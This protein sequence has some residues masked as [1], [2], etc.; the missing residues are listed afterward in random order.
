MK[1]VVLVLPLLISVLFITLVSSSNLVYLGN[2][3]M[4]EGDLYSFGTNYAVYF[5]QMNTNVNKADLVLSKGTSEIYE[6]VF[7]DESQF[8]YAGVIKATVDVKTSNS[9]GPAY[10]I[11]KDIYGLGDNSSSGTE[12]STS[13]S[14]DCVSNWKCSLWN[15]CKNGHQN[16]TC[17]DLSSCDPKNLSY[18]IDKT[19]YVQPLPSKTPCVQDWKCSEWSACVNSWFTRD[20]IDLNNCG[21]STGKPYE[22]LACDASDPAP[23]NDGNNPDNSNPNDPDNSNPNNPN[24]GNPGSNSG[25]PITNY[26]NYYYTYYTS[27]G[28]IP[29]NSS[30]P[31]GI[32]PIIPISFWPLVIG[33]LFGLL[34]LLLIYIYISS[35]FASIAERT[36]NHSPAIA[37]IPI[38]GPLL[39]ANKAS[40]MH[41]WPILLILPSA[42]NIFGYIS[43]FLPIFP[44]LFL[45]PLSSLSAL[46]T[47]VLTIY[48]FI[49]MWKTFQVL[50][51]QG[52]W[53]LFNLVPVAGN[54]IFLILLGV[55]AWGRKDINK[56]DKNKDADKDKKKK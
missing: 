25:S 34:I 33:G 13:G 23:N 41:W 30:D 31:E 22:K 12:P 52:W 46:C 21:N 4:Y 36:E 55:A 8:A 9:G 27:G 19:C 26:Y 48:S 49:W 47:L 43:I 39:I 15:A 10:I 38:L 24:N 42:L 1:K 2:Q 11:L 54:F 35:A 56:K 17:I 3:T 45:S 40:K 53:V 7:A 50:D 20:C 32:I 14:T 18:T 6:D 51:R 44:L 37:W 28:R 29:I 16:R 5:K